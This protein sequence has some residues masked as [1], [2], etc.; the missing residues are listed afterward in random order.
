MG[1]LGP[2]SLMGGEGWG[3]DMNDEVLH[4]PTS[5]Q[6]DI[7]KPSIPRL[8]CVTVMAA[9]C[10]SHI[11]TFKPPGK[12]TFHCIYIDTGQRWNRGPEAPLLRIY[13]PLCPVTHPGSRIKNP[14]YRGSIEC[15][16]PAAMIA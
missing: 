14:N 10:F 6:P 15:T 11:L 16:E 2:A 3:S 7:Q 9:P 4:F 5:C 13:G 8:S 12:S 1:H